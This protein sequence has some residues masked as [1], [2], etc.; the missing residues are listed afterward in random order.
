MASSA[1]IAA[2]AALSTEVLALFKR[3]PTA[4]LQPTDVGRFFPD[5]SAAQIKQAISYLLQARNIIQVRPNFY[6]YSGPR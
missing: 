5:N 1:Q 3:Y 4:S 2:T 6:Q